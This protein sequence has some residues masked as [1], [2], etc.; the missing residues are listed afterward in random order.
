MTTVAPGNSL[1]PLSTIASNTGWAS[2]SELLMTLRI[3]DVA[4]G[5]QLHRTEY[6]RQVLAP[7]DVEHQIRLWLPAPRGVARYL[8]INRCQEDGD[9]ADHDRDLLDLLRPVATDAPR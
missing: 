2:L 4:S 7:M 9:F 6:F 5:A 1:S 3:S 8:Y